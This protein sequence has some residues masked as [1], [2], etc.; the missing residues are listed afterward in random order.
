MT[1][2]DLRIP[3][4]LFW[5]LLWHHLEMLFLIGFPSLSAILWCDLTTCQ[6][7]VNH[8]ISGLVIYG[9]Y[10]ALLQ[11][12]RR[13]KIEALRWTADAQ[14]WDVSPS[15]CNQYCICSIFLFRGSCFFFTCFLRFWLLLAFGFCWPSVGCWLFDSVGYSTYRGMGTIRIE[16]RGFGLLWLQVIFASSCCGC[17]C[18]CSCWFV[19]WWWWWWWWEQPGL[20]AWRGGAGPSP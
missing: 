7:H 16:I 14:I 1:N 3:S 12:P 8:S 19:C 15:T 17:C 10:G 9:S 11:R 4:N 6:P 18:C 5:M 2:V 20:H 13:W